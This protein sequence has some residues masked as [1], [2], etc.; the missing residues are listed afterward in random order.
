MTNNQ[1]LMAALRKIAE[2]P[3]DDGDSLQK[4]MTKREYY[5]IM[6]LQGILAKEG[7]SYVDMQ[8]Y[9]VE[10]SVDYADELIKKLNT[11]K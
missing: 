9:I 11:K 10:K 8:S 2:N 7:I 3:V 5:A 6:A 4:D 1:Q